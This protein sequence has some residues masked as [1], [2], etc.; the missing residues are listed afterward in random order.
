[1]VTL[2]FSQQLGI[3]YLQC[4][5]TPLEMNVIQKKLPCRDKP[6]FIWLHLAAGRSHIS[7][8]SN[9]VSFVVACQVSFLNESIKSNF[10]IPIIILQ[11]KKHVFSAMQLQQLYCLCNLF[12][13]FMS[14]QKNRVG[15]YRG[16]YRL[17]LL[18]KHWQ[19]SSQA[20]KPFRQK[21]N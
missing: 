21:N 16:R 14:G 3:E 8:L 12:E 17:E 18:T 15:I 4:T 20:G 2:C 5:P 7:G 10:Q 19:Q 9:E 13:S 1:M 6:C 11:K